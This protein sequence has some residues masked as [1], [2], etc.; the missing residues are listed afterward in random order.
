MT[1]SNKIP[2]PYYH[3]TNDNSTIT[4]NALNPESN[5]GGTTGECIH[6]YTKAVKLMR[7]YA[8]EAREDF[9]SKWTIQPSAVKLEA[10]IRRLLKTALDPESN[11]GG[12]TGE[13]IHN[14]TKIGD[15][16]RRWV[17]ILDEW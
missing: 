15:L 11:N 5:N 8:A 9:F 16:S 2:R 6:N 17:K 3:D 13:C 10:T 4:K 14:H 12:T 7:W 1:T